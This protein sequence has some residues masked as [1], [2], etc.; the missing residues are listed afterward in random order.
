[1]NNKEHI[2]WAREI[3]GFLVNHVRDFNGGNKYVTYGAV[4]KSV[5]YP[6]PHTGNLFGNN[7]GKTLGVMGHLFD[8]MVI[9]GERV[10]M[11][12]ALVVSSSGKLPS[13][14]LK[15]F[16]ATYPLLTKEKKKD[17][18]Q[19]EYRK[20]FEFGDRWEEVLTRL[21][22]HNS[23]KAVQDNKQSGGLYNPYGSEGSPEH[24]A[25]RDYIAANPSIIGISIN[26][27]G[28]TEYPLK[29]GDSIDVVFEDDNSI[30]AVEVKSERSGN[31]DIERGLYQCIKYEEVLRAEIKVNKKAK[32]VVCV[33]VLADSFPLKLRKDKNIL[34]I[35][36]HENIK[37][38]SMD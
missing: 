28:I 31:D 38:P 37:P 6:A 13:D 11:L 8:D 23:K 2:F 19:I 29:S 9:N 33:L 1:M 26:V 34:G 14:G 16:N 3:L 4:A 36:V 20:I 12:Q 21:G 35:T 18:V 27:K 24:R 15:E 30:F 17:F 22:I 32:E 5:G 7:I 25:L 10:P